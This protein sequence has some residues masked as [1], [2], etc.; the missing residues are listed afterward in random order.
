MRNLKRALSVALAAVMLLGMMVIGAGAAVSIND[1]ADLDEINN[2][3]AVALMVDLGVIEGYEGANGPEFGPKNTLQRNAMAKIAYMVAT[4]AT[5]WDMYKLSTPTYKDIKGDWAEGAIE[6]CANLGYIQGAGGYFFPNDTLT[7]AATATIL[8]RTLG[9]DNDKQGYGGDQWMINAMR[10]AKDNGLLKGVSNTNAASPISRD[11]ACQMAYNALFT[12]VRVADEDRDMGEWYTKGYDVKPYTLGLQSYNLVKVTATV[13]QIAADGTVTMTGVSTLPVDTNIAASPAGNDAALTAAVTAAKTGYKYTPNMVGTNVVFYAK[14]D[15]VA[16]T[17]T[18]KVDLSYS[19]LISEVPVEGSANVLKTVTSGIADIKNA[20]DSANAAYIGVELDKDAAGT[21]YTVTCYLNGV[22]KTA[23]NSTVAGFDAD[24]TIDTAIAKAGVITEFI[25][26][27]GNGKADII[28]VTE[29]EAYVVTGDVATKVDATTKKT[30]VRIPGVINSFSTADTTETVDG[31][32]DLKKGDVVLTV[33]LGNVTYIEKAVAIEG[34]ATA[35]NSVTGIRVD[36]TYYKGSQLTAK[37]FA[38]YS[39]TAFA[40][41]NKDYTFYLDNGNNVIK[42]DV[43]AGAA[44]AV[45]YAVLLDVGYVGT[46]TEI[47]NAGYGQAQILKPDGSV[48]VV[49]ADKIDGTTIASGNVGTLKSSNAGKFHSYTENTETGVITLTKIGGATIGGT[50]IINGAAKFDTATVGNANTIFLIKTGRNSYTP[51]VGINN[52]PSMTAIT[53][54]STDMVVSG[55]V[56]SLV[57]I[58]DGI[59]AGSAGEYFYVPSIANATYVPAVGGVSAYHELAV[60]IN[61]ETTTVK[62]KADNATWA[63]DTWYT[64]LAQDGL[65]VVEEKDVNGIITSVNDDSN[66]NKL[67]DALTKVGINAASGGTL[68]VGKPATAY[69]Y[70]S[71]TAVYY[72]D[73][74]AHTVTAMDYSVLAPDA[75]DKVLVVSS[76]GTHADAVYVVPVSNSGTDVAFQAKVDGADKGSETDSTGSALTVATAATETAGKTVTLTATA[77]TGS[78]GCSIS[79]SPAAGKALVQGTTSYAFDVTVTSEDQTASETYTVTVTFTAVNAA[80]G[81]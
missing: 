7:V 59:I 14:C 13:G 20:V 75:T 44:S 53:Q 15:Y 12:N 28:K 31:Y 36:G 50:S 74:T 23:T 69:F 64:T 24:S 55:G 57:Y 70:G 9:F 11:D 39:Q 78:E 45:N 73:T 42:A 48:E 16:D 4:G 40:D 35:K 47:G 52:V 60:V 66:A 46:G 41:F 56:A 19:G 32:E 63:S 26:S 68:S 2:K 65:Y 27:N 22:T 58:T 81:G 38:A 72:V 18:K 67:D 21:N 25:D 61:G 34:K 54:A 77:K 5:D 62:L 6:Y 49:K 3:E 10:D 33:K 43:V 79:I 76:D 1:F 37:N 17:V 29:K 71:D 30:M 8:L 51:Y 80:A